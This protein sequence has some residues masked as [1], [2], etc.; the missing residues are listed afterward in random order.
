MNESCCHS[1]KKTTKRTDE[2]IKKLTVRLNRIEGQIRGLKGMLEKDAYCLDILT[3][4]AAA[5]SALDAFN[6]ELLSSHLR[7]CVTRD[8]KAGKEEESIDELMGILKLL[9]R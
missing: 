9:M 6:R 3:Q 1:G 8:I 2:E 5:T 7:T 4:S